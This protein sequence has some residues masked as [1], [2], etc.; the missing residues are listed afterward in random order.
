M[1][2]L[3]IHQIFSIMRKLFFKVTLIVLTLAV[4]CV[5]FE[6]SKEGGLVSDKTILKQKEDPKLVKTSHKNIQIERYI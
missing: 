2:K 3:F 6:R 5:F 4:T 1:S